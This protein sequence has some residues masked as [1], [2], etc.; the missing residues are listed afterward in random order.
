MQD[1]V[2]KWLYDIQ[3][4]LNEIDSYFDNTIT[5]K[6]YKNHI[7]LKRAVERDLEIIGEAINRI[8]KTDDSFKNK[9]TDAVEIVGFRNQVIHG[10]DTV[11]DEIIWSI[12]KDHLPLLKKEINLLIN[13]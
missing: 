13:E 8:I 9:I 3:Q 11:S 7:M 2:L 5:F 4:A 10:Y 1:K 12:L 6:V